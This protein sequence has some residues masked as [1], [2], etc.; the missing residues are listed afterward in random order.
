MRFNVPR[1]RE[2]R[3]TKTSFTSFAQNTAEFHDT[4]TRLTV[5][6]IFLPEFGS[7]PRY[8]ALHLTENVKVF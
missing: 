2:R 5:L 8:F 1:F 4:H 7:K 3:G 6:C